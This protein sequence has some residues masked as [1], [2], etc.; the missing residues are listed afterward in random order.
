MK[1]VVSIVLTFVVLLTM[2]VPVFALDAM[3]SATTWPETPTT[4]TTPTT[5]STPTSPTTPA[6]PVT[7]MEGQ[8]TYTV[9]KGDVMWKIAKDNGLTLKELIA[10]NP[11][12][13]NPDLIEIGQ[14]VIVKAGTPVVVTPPAP[15]AQKY[16][17]GIGLVPNYRF[18]AGNND[19][20]NIT[21]AS[22]VF[23]GNGKIVDLQWD[24]LEITP[25]MFQWIPADA[26]QA[27]KDAAGAA[28]LAWETKR[29]EGYAY[30]M[31][32][33]STGT[34]TNLT[35]KE[36]F[37]QL[38]YFEEFFKGMTVSE[39]IAWFQKYTDAVGRPYK[40]A[41]PERLSESDLVKVATFTEAEK[42]M[43]VD[44]TTSATMS[45]QD[46]HSYFIDAL[47]KAWKDRVLID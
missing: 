20:L 45:L 1:R 26:D 27:T 42:Q 21:T 5:P 14:V 10:L 15:E 25:S 41:Y 29:E 30:D 39:V 9:V 37:E 18:R 34:A 47:V 22:A 31:T 23:D 35:K 24:V 16:Y 3:T 17:L 19:N 32:R 43:L 40:M 38:D 8:V 44:V 46:P 2:A 7:N 28:V 11:Q 13:K 36:W 12:I 33:A 4:P 6:A